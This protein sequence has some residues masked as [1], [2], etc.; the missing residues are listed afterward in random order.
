MLGDDLQF[1]TDLT[2]RIHCAEGHLRGM[3]AMVER[4]TDCESLV[5]QL[6]AVQ[7]ALREI[8]RLPLKHHL[9]VCVREQLKDPDILFRERYSG[10]VV[11]LYQLLGL[12]ALLY[13]KDRA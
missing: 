5:R 4:G 8:N 6:L 11:A 9:E 2:R 7:G 10:E 3:A 13:R 12:S 1:K